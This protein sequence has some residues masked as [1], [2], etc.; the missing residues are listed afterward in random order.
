MQDLTHQVPACARSLVFV[1]MDEIDEPIV[2]RMPI[3]LWGR[4]QL[5]CEQRSVSATTA[6]K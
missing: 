2:E 1:A 5:D 6:L 3:R 4:E